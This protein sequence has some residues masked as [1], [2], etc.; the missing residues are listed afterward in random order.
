MAA[1]GALTRIDT[2]RDPDLRSRIR[3]A[4]CEFHGLTPAQLERHI[5]GIVKVIERARTGREGR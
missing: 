1:R 5:Y 2:H 3:D 4:C